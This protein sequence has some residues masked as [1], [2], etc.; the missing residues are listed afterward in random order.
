M[1]NRE[2]TRQYALSE[3]STYFKD[4]LAPY[5]SDGDIVFAL[6]SYVSSHRD[7][8][9]QGLRVLNLL[10]N[11]QVVR[12]VRFNDGG[13]HTLSASYQD[14]KDVVEVTRNDVV[15]VEVYASSVPLSSG[16]ISLDF[17]DA[18]SAHKFA[19]FIRGRI[20]K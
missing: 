3:F 20:T 19:E 8:N 13:G 4:T 10:T 16:M 6:E 7:P 15:Y 11:E 18:E 2:Y 9:L 5:I 14:I 12:M 1:T 17:P